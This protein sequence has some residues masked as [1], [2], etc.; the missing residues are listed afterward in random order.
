MLNEHNFRENIHISLPKEAKVI[1]V[2]KQHKKL[3]L[4]QSSSDM[5]NAV[6]WVNMHV[7][8]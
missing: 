3:G 5:R 8:W 1:L 4:V 6:F 2:M 7:Q